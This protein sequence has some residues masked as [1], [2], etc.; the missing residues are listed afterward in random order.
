MLGSIVTRALWSHIVD[1]KCKMIELFDFYVIYRMPSQKPTLPMCIWP[2][3]LDLPLRTTNSL[4]CCKNP[5]NSQATNQL[6]HTMPTR[7]FV[8]P[9]SEQVRGEEAVATHQLL[10]GHLHH[11]HDDR[12]HSKWDFA[13]FRLVRKGTNY[14]INLCFE[15][16][17]FTS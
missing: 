3:C 12:G 14:A 9:A 5:S 2:T 16:H 10:A 13:D 17:C 11:I 6:C 15:F 8:C 1:E 7:A 4:K